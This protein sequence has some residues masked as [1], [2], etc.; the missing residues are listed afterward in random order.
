MQ[1][2][3]TGLAEGLIFAIRALVYL[4]S[5]HQLRNFLDRFR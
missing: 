3:F 4:L 2:S 5:G 1:Q